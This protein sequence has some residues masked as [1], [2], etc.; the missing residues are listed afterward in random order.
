MPYWYV[1]GDNCPELESRSAHARGLNVTYAD[2]HAKYDSFTTQANYTY[3]KCRYEDWWVT[4]SW[5]GF[6]EP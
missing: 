3:G 5:R 1:P 2:G 6:V 4:N